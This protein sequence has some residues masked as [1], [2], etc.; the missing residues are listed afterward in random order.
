M[1]VDPFELP[2]VQ[3]E[4]SFYFAHPINI[5]KTEFKEALLAKIR[6]RFPGSSIV[7]PDTPEHQ[8][9]YKQFGMAY[10]TDTVLR[11]I[12]GVVFLAFR[13]GMVGAGV[14]A[15][16]QKV[17]EN[18]GVCFEIKPDGSIFECR[19][20]DPA[21]MLSVEATRERIRHEDRTSK[22]Y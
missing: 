1:I 13:D 9:G 16:A 2:Q 5:F 10:Y 4:Q 3:E 17:I 11:R 8:E 7:D 14:Y 20:L 6:K 15:E 21:R 12:R 22:P 19:A 18:G